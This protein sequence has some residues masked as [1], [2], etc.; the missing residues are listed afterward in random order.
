VEN[1][2]EEAA[3]SIEESIR[4]SCPTCKRGAINMAMPTIEDL[5]A[6][7]EITQ[8]FDRVRR[9]FSPGM[10][11]KLRRLKG[12]AGYLHTMIAGSTDAS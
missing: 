4:Q 6:L 2:Y 11:D 3:E 8:G 7:I 12:L 9:S 5:E 10:E 1:M